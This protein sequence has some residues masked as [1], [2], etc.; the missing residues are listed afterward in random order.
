MTFREA[1]R[2]NPG[3]VQALHLMGLAYLQ[4]SDI[5]N[6]RSSFRELVRLDPDLYDPRVRLAELDVRSGDFQSAID[7]CGGHARKRGRK[8]LFFI[9]CLARRTSAK[10]IP[11][12]RKRL[13]QKYLEKSPRDARG[14]YLLG[15]AL[16]RSGKTGGSGQVFRGGSQCL[17]PGYG[18]SGA[19]CLNR[20]RRKEPGFRPEARHET[21]R[22]L[23]GQC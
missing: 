11:S 12:K 23:S 20:Y 13:I 6:A 21:N 4:E 5:A 2:I 10:K 9:C 19:A 14:K 15:L 16:L 1:L 3:S 22:D 7:N 18:F 8:N 17:S